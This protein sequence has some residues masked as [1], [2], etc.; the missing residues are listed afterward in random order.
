MSDARRPNS[1]DAGGSIEH[2]DPRMKSAAVLARRH[3]I[4]FNTFG[5]SPDSSQWRDQALGQIAGATGGTYHAIQDPRQL[6]CHLASSL[7]PPYLQEQRK[8]QGAF[9]R[10]RERQASSSKG[11]TQPGELPGGE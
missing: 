11:A 2:L 6:Y 4:V 5:L 1:V 3:R 10:Y 7:L 8:W 9:T